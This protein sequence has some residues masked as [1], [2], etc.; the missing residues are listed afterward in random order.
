MLLPRPL[1]IELLNSMSHLFYKAFES[2]AIRFHAAGL[3][4]DGGVVDCVVSEAAGA[5]QWAGDNKKCLYESGLVCQGWGR[6]SRSIKWIFI[7]LSI[8]TTARAETSGLLNDTGQTQCLNITGTALEECTPAN[9]GNNSPYPGQD[10]RYGRDAAA[11][12]AGQSNFSKP[13]GSSGHGGFAFTPLDLNGNQIS[14]IGD[15]PVPSQTPRCIWDRTTN[16][17]WEVKT[18]DGGLQDKS[19]DYA[20]GDNPGTNCF[21]GGNNCNTNSYITALNQLDICHRTG[22]GAWRLPSRR[23]LISILD[24]GNYRPAI[25]KAYFPDTEIGG[26]YWSND[27][28]LGMSGYRWVVQTYLGSAK[29]ESPAAS[30]GVRLVKYGP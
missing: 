3:I 8:A 27:V 12:H 10:G 28:Y 20:W 7:G 19:W 11:K 13:E 4:S 14:L 29:S 25:D 2:I 6:M 5:R 15:P 17:I 26:Y 24:F 9:S 16:L 22:D 1:F 30:M 21:Y 23:E 18:S